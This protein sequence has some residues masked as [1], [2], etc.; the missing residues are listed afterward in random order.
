[1]SAVDVEQA[2]YL[3]QARSDL[4]AYDLLTAADSCHRMHYLQMATEKL[5]KA[6]FWRVGQPLKKRHDYFMKFMR[7]VGSNGNVGKAVGIKTSNHWEAYID[8]V[9]PVAQV[10]EGM[11]PT[12]ADD[13]PNAEY[14]WPHEAP[15]SAPANY[16]FPLEDELVTPR[17]KRFLDVLRRLLDRFE[18]YA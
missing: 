10:I 13:G 15:V 12:E 9:L 17:G 14:P 1:V 8:G 6:Y 4:R 11:A 7:A 18:Q 2:L 3:T 5:S 16:H